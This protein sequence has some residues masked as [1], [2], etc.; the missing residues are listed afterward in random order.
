MSTR[1]NKRCFCCATLNCDSLWIVQILKI[2]CNNYLYGITIFALAWKIL[3]SSLFS[4]CVKY[5]EMRAFS[6][7]DFSV[8]GQN[9]IR[10]NTDQRKPVFWD[11]S[12]NVS[13]IIFAFLHEEK[14]CKIVKAIYTFILHS[15][16][17]TKMLWKWDCLTPCR[18]PR[19]KNAVQMDFLREKID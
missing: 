18:N 7:L 9:R 17:K 15:H 6:D 16:E 12:R 3:W 13:N 1:K 4:Q 19:R 10:E 5:P 2:E 11:T 8:Y 14:T